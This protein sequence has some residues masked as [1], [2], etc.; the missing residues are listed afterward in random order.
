[1][2]PVLLGFERVTRNRNQVGIGPG[3]GCLG[4]AGPHV[5]FSGR[6]EVRAELALA[7][8]NKFLALIIVAKN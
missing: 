2:K 1:M 5:L 6:G 7:E 8:L 4:I 3:F